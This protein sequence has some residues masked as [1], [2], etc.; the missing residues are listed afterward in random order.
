MYTVLS[1][2]EW[3]V[4]NIVEHREAL[5]PWSGH[6]RGVAHIV[7]CRQSERLDSWNRYYSSCAVDNNDGTYMKKVKTMQSE[8]RVT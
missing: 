1:S 8:M 7:L 4:F 6:F 5:L 2:K 3:S